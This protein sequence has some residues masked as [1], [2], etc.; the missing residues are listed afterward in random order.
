M[1]VHMDL[2]HSPTLIYA[3]KFVQGHFLNFNILIME[4]PPALKNPGVTI[5]CRPRMTVANATIK[6]QNPMELMGY[7]GFLIFN[8][9][10]K[11]P[12]QQELR[13]ST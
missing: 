11:I 10:G 3:P 13:D 1:V 5:T 12:K 4:A 8:K 2:S 7:Q 9:H 6:S